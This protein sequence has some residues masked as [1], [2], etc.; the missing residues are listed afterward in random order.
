[1]WGTLRSE[2]I[3][4][5]FTWATRPGESALLTAMQDCFKKHPLAGMDPSFR[6]LD[7]GKES[8]GPDWFERFFSIV[9]QIIPR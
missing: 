7:V 1:M 8:T 4:T 3:G 2:K 6:D 9:S 5:A